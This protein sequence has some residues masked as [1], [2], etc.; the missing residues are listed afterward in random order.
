M[1]HEETNGASVRLF[2][3][4]FTSCTPWKRRPVRVGRSTRHDTSR[5]GV[6]REC[7]S[8]ILSAAC[9]ID[10]SNCRG[11]FTTDDRS[12]GITEN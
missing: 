8:R 4:G 11:P 10:R 1:K 7:F 6:L 9:V 12:I 3:E 2:F 5:W